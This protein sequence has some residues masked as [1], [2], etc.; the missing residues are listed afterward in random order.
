MMRSEFLVFFSF[1]ELVKLSLTSKSTKLFVDPNSQYI[2][3]TDDDENK[4]T[5]FDPELE[6]KIKLHD[7]LTSIHVMHCTQI[8]MR[9][10]KF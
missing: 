3:T 6:G 2:T 5:W 4:I 7:H 9:T 10:Q 8:S 1:K